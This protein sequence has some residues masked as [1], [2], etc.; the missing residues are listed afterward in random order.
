MKFSSIDFFG[1]TVTYRMEARKAG[2]T[3]FLSLRSSDGVHIDG[4]GRIYYEHKGRICRA[5]EGTGLE[6]YARMLIP[7]C[8]KRAFDP[9]TEEGRTLREKFAQN[10]PLAALI[11]ADFDRVA[12]EMGWANSTQKDHKKL[13]DLLVSKLG[14]M[15]FC[16]ITQEMF[17]FHLREGGFSSYQIN[18]QIC[19]FRALI[20]YEQACHLIS[21]HFIDTFTMGNRRTVVGPRDASRHFEKNILTHAQARRIIASCAENLESNHGYLYLG[22]IL[23]LTTGITINELCALTWGSFSF[24]NTYTGVVAIEISAEAKSAGEVYHTEE[25]NGPRRRTIPLSPTMAKLYHKV[26]TN[27]PNVQ[28][29]APFMRSF[30]NAARR[31]RPDEFDRWLKGFFKSFHFSKQPELKSLTKNPERTL[32]ATFRSALESCGCDEEEIRYLCGNAPKSVFA[33]NY[34]A[35]DDPRE[36]AKLAAM[37]DRYIFSLM[38]TPDATLDFKINRSGEDYAIAAAPGSRI[39]GDLTVDLSKISHDNLEAGRDLIINFKS[40]DSISITTKLNLEE[41]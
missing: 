5:P 31:M 11:A 6:E 30:K 32:R 27:A 33:R 26:K 15:P 36:L 19:A 34:C 14:W 18:G 24:S 28:E 4:A 9:D 17:A 13:L 12:Q 10:L 39:S 25:L 29:N 16:E 41:S 23:M 35:Y 8:L 1:A 3:V 40:S 22:L 2:P 37:L 7:E 21:E 20:A 38:G